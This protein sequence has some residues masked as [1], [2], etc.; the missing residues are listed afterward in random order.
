MYDEIMIECK[1]LPKRVVVDLGKEFK[2]GLFQ[3]YNSDNEIELVFCYTSKPAYCERF[4]RTIQSLIYKYC[5]QYQTFKFH[6]KL[7]DFIFT[8][9]SK[10]NR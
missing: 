3:R 2:N 6:D 9:N 7:Q 5:T 10:K 8:Y 4:N 1:T